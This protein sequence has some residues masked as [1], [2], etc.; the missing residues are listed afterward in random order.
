M[1]HSRLSLGAP[2]IRSKVEMLF[3]ICLTA[4]MSR[5]IVKHH[6]IKDKRRSESNLVWHCY[7][8]S[9]MV[10]GM[11]SIASYT[12]DRKSEF[13]YMTMAI[14]SWFLNATISW[15]VWPTSPHARVTRATSEKTI[16]QEMC[17]NKDL[18]SCL[19]LIVLTACGS[20]WSTFSSRIS[21]DQA[22]MG[23]QTRRAT[24]ERILFIGSYGTSSFPRLKI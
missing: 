5:H 14:F 22:R 12:S 18:R 24:P 2:R 3:S 16:V 13:Q 20:H 11:S 1:L 23:P 15:Q 9:H 7:P 10:A 17:P 8:G 19:N 4:T 6:R 21:S